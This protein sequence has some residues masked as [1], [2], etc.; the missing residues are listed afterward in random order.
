MEKAEMNSLDVALKAIKIYAATHPRPHQV[1]QKQ[2]AQMLDVSEATICK[3]VKTGRIRLNNAGM[4]SI[5]EID[6][7]LETA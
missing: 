6:R 2:A 4:I 3:W 5:I 7:L 1:N